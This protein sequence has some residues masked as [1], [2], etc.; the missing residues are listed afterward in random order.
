MDKESLLKA[1]EFLLNINNIDMP[2]CD[3]FEIL[4]T[5]YILLEPENFEKHRDV[6]AREFNE[7]L[8]WKCKK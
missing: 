5:L 8:R 4:N 7:E 2:I 6:L 3:K 1:R